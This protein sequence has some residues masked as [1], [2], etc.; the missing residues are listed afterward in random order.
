MKKIKVHHNSLTMGVKTIAEEGRPGIYVAFQTK[1]YNKEAVECGV[2]IFDKK[3]GECIKRHVIPAENSIGNVRYDVI[4]DTNYKDISYLFFE[5]EKVWTDKYAGAYVVEGSYGEQKAADDYKAVPVDHDY[6]WEESQK[7]GIAYADSIMYCMHVRG[8]T[9]HESSGVK[10]KGT[11][12]GVTEKIPYLKE[13]GITTL[14]LQ[15]CYEFE[16]V[17]NI[18]GKVD[19]KHNYWGYK[20]GYYYAPK[21]RYAYSDDAVGEFKDFIKTCHKNN[22][23]VIMQF[24][25]PDNVSRSEIPVILRYWS[26]YYQVDG[27]HLK[28]SGL[29]LTEIARDPYLA[30]VKL[31]HRDFTENFI[32]Q[33]GKQS[34]KLPENKNL[35]VYDDSFMYTMRRFL[36]SDDGV[37]WDAI[38]R[39]RRNPEDTGVVNCFTNYDGF[40][41]MD[42]VSYNRKHNEKNGEKNRDGKDYNFTWN[43]GEE[44]ASKRSRVLKLRRKQIQN[45]FAMLML[46][47][48]TPLFFMGDEFG[49]SQQGNNN[50]YCQDNEIT[51]L[52]WNDME[53]NADIFEFVKK[54]IAIRRE[55]KV[56]HQDDECRMADYK[57]Y[58]YPDLSYHNEKA[59]IPE[60]DHESRNFGFMLYG[61][62]AEGCQGTNWYVAI[63]MHWEPREFA[64]PKGMKWEKYL[65]TENG[66]ENLLI[67][68]EGNE[69]G[70]I[71]QNDTRTVLVA[72][73]SIAVFCSSKQAG[74]I[75]FG[76]I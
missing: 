39:M 55:N 62:Y 58:G 4:N 12:A 73:R 9:K 72:P 76:T 16:E 13:L 20:E 68:S 54:L 71:S 34:G 2:L 51:W 41:M 37:I 21:A 31:M 11:F 65:T 47:Q 45:A 26:Y 44:G 25:F 42:M 66:E 6:D 18:A 49:N 30:D 28:G 36:K 15:P 64:M 32:E 8:F 63:N 52:D 27:F 67:E 35:A 53:K 56:F 61:D 33:N 75:C 7:P 70:T 57:F 38:Y 10:A 19:K 3:T 40:T 59:W 46:S 50:P 60:F 24:Y 17:G 22:I 1:G 69:A 48:G 74:K 5:G 23:E 29:P 43:C 14:E